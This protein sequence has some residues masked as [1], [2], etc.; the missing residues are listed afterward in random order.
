MILTKYQ[1]VNN[2]INE[3]TDNATESITPYHIRHNLLDIID[4]V[5][6]ILRY[7]N[8]VS[9]NVKT[10][11]TRTSIFGE[12]ALERIDL[13]N[14]SSEDNSAFGYSAMRINF[15]G[16][17]N[18]SIG[19]YSL[20][21]NIYGSDNVAVG[22]QSLSSNVLGSGN[23]GIGNFSLSSARTGSFNIA[24]GHGA[25]YYVDKDDSYQFY[26]GSHPVDSGVV[27]DDVDGSTIT[28]LLRGDLN[29]N[30]LGI[31]TKSFPSDAVL[32]V[33]GNI[34]PTSDNSYDI[35]S[36]DLSWR[37]FYSK[38]YNFDG[39]RHFSNQDSYVSFNFDLLPDQNNVRSFG[40]NSNKI[41]SIYTSNLFVNDFASIGNIEL[42]NSSVYH[43]KTLHLAAKPSNIYLDGG[44][45][46]SLY[47]YALSDDDS[48][49]PPYLD[50]SKVNGAGISVYVADNPLYSN[51]NFLLDTQ[52]NLGFPFW[53]SNISLELADNTY[54]KCGKI[55]SGN[56]F[57]IDL[58]SEGSTSLLLEPYTFYYGDK[59][60]TQNGSP[61]LFHL[62]VRSENSISSS[63]LSE[64]RYTSILQKYHSEA[65]TQSR[66]GFEVK[67]ET[68]AGEVTEIDGV[69]VSGPD[70]ST[71]SIMAFSP[72]QS[73]QSRINPLNSLILNRDS[74]NNIFGIS[75][76][77]NY[78]PQ[79]TADF[80]IQDNCILRLKSRGNNK[81]S[82]INLDTKDFG[83]ARLA[84]HDGLVFTYN[85]VVASRIHYGHVDLFNN[86]SG[87]HN[88]TLNIGDAL[89]QEA[90]IGLKHTKLA[91]V[92]ASGYAA[93]FTQEKN[94]ELQK[95]SLIFLDQAGNEFDV[96]RSPYNTADGLMFIDDDGN[97]TGGLNSLSKKLEEGFSASNNTF[98]GFDSGKEVT[99]GENNTLLGN[100]AGSSLTTGSNNIG[101][102]HKALGKNATNNY[103]ICIGLD[104]FSDDID[105][106][107]NFALGVSS[108]KLLMRG[109]LGPSNDDKYLELPNNG[110]LKVSNSTNSESVNI[111]ANSI[112]VEDSGGTDF[113]DF[114]LDFN[115]IG[116]SSNTLLSLNHSE[117]PV[118][119]TPTY[120]TLSG[121]F[122]QLNG[123]LKLLGS[124][125][126]S[127]G[128]I[129]S[130]SGE[131]TINDI[132]TRQNEVE[133]SFN[134]IFIEGTT[135]RGIDSPTDSSSP[136]SGPIST[137][138]GSVK[139]IHNRDP[140]LTIKSGVYVVA[141]KIGEE[142]RPIWISSE[143]G[144]LVGF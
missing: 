125:H 75:D 25:G 23:V 17:R 136:T 48:L 7:Q 96:I 122:A 22:Y 71:L 32:Q 73:E 57:S 133:A 68:K 27:C 72:T 138:D 91:P 85:G 54:F 41:N 59:A 66:I 127:D 46:Y 3:I 121:P 52:S 78:I 113:P 132:E 101:I 102:G 34:D 97:T 99:T 128:S 47:D 117:D 37:N 116:N 4:S 58:D 109:I 55:N 131:D 30:K 107:Y 82:A 38:N 61:D 49:I 80:N 45:A 40:S 69:E 63:Y 67:Y 33:G 19:S 31:N 51:Y 141:A 134:S 100:A 135:S 62:T 142:Y 29:E 95:S 1:L 20:K 65:G 36:S 114:Q 12:S 120:A 103:N 76:E 50:D 124:I 98:I 10:Y 129:L 130:S 123:H 53:K 115:F 18:T 143:F 39:D 21:T 15:K 90:S 77:N 87:T 89:N 26:L 118:D 60:Y 9:E 139:M 24:I 42:V 93:I 83:N 28:P 105:S 56:S 119:K 44:G 88:F 2:I 94:G 43:N 144:S 111:T 11:E 137:L 106:D 8:I 86:V 104:T 6:E 13:A 16:H 79:A 108:N 70:K 5:S 140:N 64:S 14:H 84:C 81:I 110:K 74:R 126:F 35:G 112:N 92:S